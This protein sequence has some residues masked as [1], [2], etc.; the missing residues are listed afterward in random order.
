MEM[1]EPRSQDNKHNV[2]IGPRLRILLKVVLGL[3]ALLSI[4]SLYLLVVTGLGKSTGGGQQG[5]FYLWMFLV[6]LA[7]GVV[8]IIPVLTFA[9]LHLR[10]AYTSPK[11]NAVYAGGAGPGHQANH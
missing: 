4:N 3:F 1:N 7:L 6:H 2:V 9:V 11:R 8:L 5:T 10:K